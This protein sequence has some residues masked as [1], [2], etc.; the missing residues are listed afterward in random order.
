MRD[1]CGELFLTRRVFWISVRCKLRTIFGLY[2]G[3]YSFFR[4]QNLFQKE[5]IAL[6]QSIYNIE[7]SKSDALCFCLA[8]FLSYLI[9]SYQPR[10]SWS[11]KMSSSPFFFLPPSWSDSVLI[12]ASTTTSLF[13]HFLLLLLLPVF[14]L[15]PP[16]LPAILNLIS[17]LG[18]TQLNNV[19]FLTE[20]L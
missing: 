8:I 12:L 19:I 13:R 10:Q 15:F 3:F 9:L 5:K 4:I 20:K 18:K 6:S 1:F 17:I 11:A 14:T 7:L 16:T 2:D